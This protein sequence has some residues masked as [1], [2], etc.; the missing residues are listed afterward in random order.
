MSLKF[1]TWKAVL[2]LLETSCM[3]LGPS[4]VFYNCI[5]DCYRKVIVVFV[6]YGA[7]GMFCDGALF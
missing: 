2:S 7:T 1:K 4:C 3:V 6:V 5:E